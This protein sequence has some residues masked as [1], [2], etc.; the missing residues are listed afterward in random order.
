MSWTTRIACGAIALLVSCG[1]AAPARESACPSC[2]DADTLVARFGL[3]EAATPV[4]ERAGWRPP[5]RIVT[6][7]G[8][9][10]VA[11]LRSAAP[12]AE[13][14]G[15]NDVAEAVRALR[16]ADVY[17]GFC[18]AAIAG[19]GT[20]LRWVQLRSAGADA[21]LRGTSLAERGVLLT[22]AQGLYGPQVADHALAL[23]L[24]LTRQLHQ[25][26]DH[27]RAGV[28]QEERMPASPAWELDG[29]TMLVVGLGGIGTEIARRAHAF[30]MR[31]VGT[32][33]SRRE[34]PPFVAYVGLGA[35][36]LEL[37]RSA[38]VVVNAAPLTDDTRA[39]FNATFFRAL[40]PGALF[41]NIGRGESVVTADLVEALRGGRLG[42]AGL[43]VTDPEPLPAG[44]PL[45]SLPN[46][47]ITP[48][49]AGESDGRDRRLLT[50]AVENLRRYVAGER[51]LSVVDAERGY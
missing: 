24:A 18:N 8:A 36:A 21:C 4:R 12:A 31:I 49:T 47:V 27:Q 32:R 44:H 43:D 13:V 50:L 45:W 17:V 10:W 34:A 48:H 26:R 16:G 35:E 5:R 19:A 28:W 42:G 46:V 14:I 1:A 39:L 37:A 22:N 3:R 7:G 6:M 51:L 33:N 41:I 29:K 38:D 2:L 20:G 40:K 30:G 15:V 23:L 11:A 25:Y 9:E